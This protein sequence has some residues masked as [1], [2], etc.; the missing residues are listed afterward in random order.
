VPRRSPEPKPERTP[1]E[2]ADLI[3]RAEAYELEAVKEL[4]YIHH[5]EDDLDVDPGDLAARAEMAVVALAA[6]T[7]SER[8]ALA[9]R[10]GHTRRE[11][12]G[13]SPT[14]IERLLVDRIVTCGLEL[15]YLEERF[16]QT[17]RDGDVAAQKHLDHLVDR[18]HRRYLLAIKMLAQ[19][20]R[21]TVPVVQLNMA[22]QQVNV[23]IGSSPGSQLP[24]EAR[25]DAEQVTPSAPPREPDR[26]DALVSPSPG[27]RGRDAG[28][29]SR[30]Q[31]GPVRSTAWRPPPRPG[32]SGGRRKPTSD[33]RLTRDR[34]PSPHPGIRSPV[35][36]P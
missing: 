28:N 20:R 18:A 36:G 1:E 21:L 27:R 14:P 31:G 3:R 5:D 34:G 2:H 33:A 35:R 7:V 24:G 13:P 22:N 11:L 32:A 12:D 30:E 17:L 9:R 19:V 16:A 6:T 15:S 23:A 25:A 26:D 29:G 8:A 4:S 10:L